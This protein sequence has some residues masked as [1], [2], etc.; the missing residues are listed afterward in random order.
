LPCSSIIGV[1]NYYNPSS[2]PAIP[3]TW[4]S[5]GETLVNLDVSAPINVNAGDILCAS[6]TMGN[7]ILD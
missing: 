2:V 4:I 3:P 6:A 5:S 1:F 7:N